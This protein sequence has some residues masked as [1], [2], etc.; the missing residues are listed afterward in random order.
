MGRRKTQFANGLD[1]GWQSTSVKLTEF[2]GLSD[3]NEKGR[4]K[5]KQVCVCEGEDSTL[6]IHCLSG[7]VQEVGGW[8]SLKLEGIVWGRQIWG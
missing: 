6:S 4:L 5:E 8:M 7:Y 2:S 3:K 1:V